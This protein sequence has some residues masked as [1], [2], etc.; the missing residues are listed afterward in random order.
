M[1][2]DVGTQIKHWLRI[3]TL[4]TIALYLLLGAALGYGWYALHRDEA[5]TN[6][7]LCSLRADREQSNASSREFLREHPHGIP[8]ISPAAI[9]QGIAN[10]QRTIDSLSG[11]R[12]ND[13][14][15]NPANSQ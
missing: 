12:C 1:T 2:E 6:T 15:T 11:L 3:L 8:G 5:R 10:Q 13:G 4:S 14:T 7:A 9:R